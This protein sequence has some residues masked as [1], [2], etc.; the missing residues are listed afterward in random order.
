M[1]HYQNSKKISDNELN[2]Q[3][4]S[5]AK[6]SIIYDI[7]N[8]KI[9]L[10]NNAEIKYESVTLKAAYIELDS[11]KNIVFAKS[12]VNDSTGENYGYPFLLKMIKSFNSE[13]ITYNFNT[14]KGIIKEVRTQEG[15]GYIIGEKVKKLR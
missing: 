8:N 10:Y 11:D 15:E 7:L 2:E 4:V 9:F 5:Y 13:E 1:I 12:L 14:K 6:D 3:V